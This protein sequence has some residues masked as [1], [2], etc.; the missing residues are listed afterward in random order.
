MAAKMS[1]CKKSPFSKF[2]QVL[3]LN[4]EMKEKSFFFTKVIYFNKILFWIIRGIIERTSVENIFN[5]SGT[6]VDNYLIFFHEGVQPTKT[7]S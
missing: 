1:T 6:L 5:A 7:S 4:F 2:N 3:T